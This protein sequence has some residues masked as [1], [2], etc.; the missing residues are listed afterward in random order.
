MKYS[1]RVNEVKNMDGNI[2]GFATVVFSDSFKVTNIAI[3]ENK[4][5]GQLF[6]SMPR[7]KSNERD[8]NGNVYKDVCNPIKREFREEL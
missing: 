3:L 4:E 1:I 2:R 6:V 8:G 5:K 7:Y